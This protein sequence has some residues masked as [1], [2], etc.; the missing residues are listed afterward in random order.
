MNNLWVPKVICGAVFRRFDSVTNRLL[1]VKHKGQ[2]C[3]NSS[4]I[5]ITTISFIDTKTARYTGH[6]RKGDQI[7]LRGKVYVL[8]EATTIN[9]KY[10]ACTG[11]CWAEDK[12][13][14][15]SSTCLDKA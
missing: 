1:L 3:F 13:A 15:S 11:L 14:S 2:I 5:R 12:G 6:L 4:S 10:T 8:A 7:D 9:I